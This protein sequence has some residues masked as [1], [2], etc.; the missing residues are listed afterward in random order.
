MGTAAYDN[1]RAFA[2]RIVEP[3]Y[4]HYGTDVIPNEHN[5]DRF[6]R[7]LAINLAC[8]AGV[9]SCLTDVSE[10]LEN[11]VNNVTVIS[12]DVQLAIY[13]HGLRQTRNDASSTAFSFLLDVMLRSEYQAERTLIQTALG[14]A[15]NAERLTEYLELALRPG[16]ARLLLVERLRIF[17]IAVNSNELGLQVMIDFVR[18]NFEAINEVQQ[19]QSNT[20]LSEI[21][22]RVASVEILEEFET[23]LTEFED[24][25]LITEDFAVTLRASVNSNFEW[26]EK[27]VEQIRNL[28]QE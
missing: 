24:S 19:G 3:L 5:F 16:E 8:A 10:I 21:A 9:E 26:Q 4:N 13:C 12:P 11:V 28:L 1:F 14:C 20:I 22:I 25:E 6:A 18:E 2:R 23:L 27:F 7:S 17:T 15:E